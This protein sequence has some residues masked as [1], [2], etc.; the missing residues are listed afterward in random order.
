M[1]AKAPEQKWWKLTDTQ[2]GI[3][4]L[5]SANVWSVHVNNFYDE[6]EV[7]VQVGPGT[8]YVFPMEQ[9]RPILDWFDRLAELPEAPGVLSLSL[10]V[11]Q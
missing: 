7:R 9:A 8:D 1:K 2:G 10:R 4:Y 11:K 5:S 3:V 6:P